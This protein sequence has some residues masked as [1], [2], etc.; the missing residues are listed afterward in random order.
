MKKSPYWTR[1]GISFIDSS[2]CFSLTHIHLRRSIAL[3]KQVNEEDA[4]KKLLIPKN[5][6][7]EQK[8]DC[9]ALEDEGKREREKDERNWLWHASFPEPVCAAEMSALIGPAEMQRPIMRIVRAAAEEGS[10]KVQKKRMYL[11][12]SPFLCSCRSWQKKSARGKDN[13]CCCL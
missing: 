1:K 12:N 4:R 9:L 13:R 6:W 11:T 10:R 3:A 2:M 8:G 5:W 7:S